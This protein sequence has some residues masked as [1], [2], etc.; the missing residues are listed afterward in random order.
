MNTIAIDS[1]KLEILNVALAAIET[2][3]KNGKVTVDELGPISSAIALGIQPPYVAKGRKPFTR[4]DVSAPA[5]SW[6]HFADALAQLE[7]QEWD[8]AALQASTKETE[9]P[10]KKERFQKRLGF[11]NFLMSAVR[12]AVF[13][14]VKLEEEAVRQAEQKAAR[15]AEK[16]RRAAALAALSDEERAARKAA[17]EALRAEQSRRD[18]A[19]KSLMAAAEFNSSAP[20]PAPTRDDRGRT[21]RQ[22]PPLTPDRVRD[23]LDRKERDLTTGNRGK[24]EALRDACRWMVGLVLREQNRLDDATLQQCKGEVTI[25]AT[26]AFMIDNGGNMAEAERQAQSFLDDCVRFNR[27]KANLAKGKPSRKPKASNTKR[28]N[29]PATER[30]PEPVV[31]AKTD[32]APAPVEPPAPEAKPRRV[33]KPAPPPATCYVS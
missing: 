18:Q 26:S 33:S 4:K 16:A 27:N 14:A 29:A 25:A 9:D 20:A 11:M 19:R 6:Q 15:E 1:K 2:C 3:Q 7:S 32:P 8:R 10:M 31:Q 12:G 22:H 23:L 30:S 28:D 21:V 24:G 5:G 13:Y 17:A